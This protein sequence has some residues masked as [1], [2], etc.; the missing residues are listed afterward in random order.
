MKYWLKWLITG[1]IFVS[2][3]TLNYMAIDN[4]MCKEEPRRM[5]TGMIN[6]QTKAWAYPRQYK[7][8][9]FIDDKPFGSLDE[10]VI[11]TKEGE[12]K[13]LKRGDVG[14]DEQEEVYKKEI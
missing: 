10:V 9:N 12:R 8:R 5:Y 4:Q 11:I 14:F 3:C 13:E 2:P 7:I 6:P 1:A